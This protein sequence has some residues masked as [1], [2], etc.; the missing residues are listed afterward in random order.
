MT[1][2]LKD[3]EDTQELQGIQGP[4]VGQ[5]SLD[6]KG[7]LEKKEDMEHQVTLKLI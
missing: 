7:S 4:L 5:E 3:P 2:P 1:W 6:K